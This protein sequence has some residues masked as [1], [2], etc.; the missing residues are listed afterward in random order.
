MSIIYPFALSLMAEL[1]HWH[2]T[3]TLGVPISNS[4][5]WMECSFWNANLI[6]YSLPPVHLKSFQGAPCLQDKSKL[7]RI[8]WLL[9]KSLSPLP[10]TLGFRY[11]ELLI[12]LFQA[13]M[14]TV[15]ERAV[16]TGISFSSFLLWPSLLL[17]MGS[18]PCLHPPPFLCFQCAMNLLLLRTS[19]QY[20]QL[21]V[22]RIFLK[23]CN[24]L[25]TGSYWGTEGVVALSHFCLSS[26]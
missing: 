17:P 22:N 15:F 7:P 12:T 9:P 26:T 1:C 6:K 19:T 13:S 20:L 5:C 25:V 14:R 11:I 10:W 23:A 2:H 21:W 16:L 4:S 18:S 24:N 3:L 8:S